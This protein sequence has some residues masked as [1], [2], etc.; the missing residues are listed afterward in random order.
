MSIYSQTNFIV[1]KKGNK[2]I[3]KDNTINLSERNILYSIE[4]STW[5]K[6][7]RL[8]DFEYASIGTAII[9]PFKLTGKKKTQAYFVFAEKK[10]KKL[11]GSSLTFT[12]TA[13]KVSISRTFYCMYVIDNDNNII[14]GVSFNSHTKSN[15]IDDKVKLAPMVRKYFS[16]CPQIIEALNKYDFPDVNGFGITGFFNNP[17]YI[18]CE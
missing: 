2:I 15:E 9:K 10:D 5:E 12:S 11:I 17:A 14:E 13:Y 1:D 16:D 3:V 18:K 7:L 4:K 6:N 8:D